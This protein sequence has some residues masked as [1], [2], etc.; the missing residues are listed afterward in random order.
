MQELLDFIEIL[1]SKPTSWKNPMVFCTQ[2]NN[3]QR[4]H[5]V[6]DGMQLLSRVSPISAVR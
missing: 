5:G 2:S 3:L 6:D 1:P 4:Y